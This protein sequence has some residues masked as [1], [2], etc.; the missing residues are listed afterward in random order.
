MDVGDHVDV[1][2]I[3]RKVG[4][5]EVLDARDPIA[6][7]VLRPLGDHYLFRAPRSFFR[8]VKHGRWRIDMPSP[9]LN[10]FL[11]VEEG[12]EPE[13]EGRKALCLAVTERFENEDARAL[14]S[15]LRTHVEIDGPDF[16]MRKAHGLEQ[17]VQ[18]LASWQVWATLFGVPASALLARLGQRAGDAIWDGV[19]GW[20]KSDEAKPLAGV[21]D[22][23]AQIICDSGPAYIVIGLDVPNQY[24]DPILI[25]RETDP[26][27]IALALAKFVNVSE[28]ISIAIQKSFA[29]GNDLLDQPS[30]VLS[31]H[32]N[33][34]VEW[35]TLNFVKRR[36]R[37]VKPQSS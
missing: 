15:A 17:F 24:F 3:G 21:S 18:L 11:P 8:L 27:K 1:T 5:G 22:V 31:E 30:I 2:V 37:V 10:I 34:V 4:P 28:N 20:L 12:C 33:A 16:F 29:H 32:G 23:L 26:E 7:R 36:L 14:A 13:S 35:T 9:T 19:R 6:V 25:I